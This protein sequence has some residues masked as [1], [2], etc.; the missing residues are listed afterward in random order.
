MVK[1]IV[2]LSA[3]FLFGICGCSDNSPEVAHLKEAIRQYDRLLSEGYSNMDMNP[4]KQITSQEQYFRVFQHMMALKDSQLKLES[5]L[6][7]LTIDEV[8]F[9][10]GN[11]A[12]VK[13]KEVW[14]F[15]QISI[16]TGKTEF[17]ASDAVHQL[18]YELEK[19]SNKWLISSVT[20]A[21]EKDL[22]KE[23]VNKRIENK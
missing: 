11:K 10:G 13:A 7:K 19:K 23:S 6:K 22:K 12:F 20:A 2:L 8:Q 3:F 21:D 4:L 14:D 18:T 16:K 9:V 15:S 5:K 1:R 17:E